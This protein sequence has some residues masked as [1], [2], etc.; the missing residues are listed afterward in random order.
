MY[1]ITRENI[2]NDVYFQVRCFYE[3]NAE[4]YDRTLTDKR[5]PFDPSEAYI[6]GNE[7]YSSNAHAQRLYNKCRRYIELKTGAYFD[8]LHWK[9]CM[10]E[11]LYAQDWINLYE[12]MIKEN[13]IT[14]DMVKFL[15]VKEKTWHT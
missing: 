1:S 7:K 14:D 4:L 5:S 8:N 6:A 11:Y 15:E 2:V 13:I 10:N 9:R 12:Y 3:A